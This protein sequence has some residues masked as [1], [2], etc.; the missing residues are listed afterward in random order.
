MQLAD[1]TTTKPD[2]ALD[3]NER[4]EL[5]SVISFARNHLA[6]GNA[7]ALERDLIALVTIVQPSP[8]NK[9]VSHAQ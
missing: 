6:A 5:M 3:W 1:P 7:K 8:S 4:S 9:G 2:P